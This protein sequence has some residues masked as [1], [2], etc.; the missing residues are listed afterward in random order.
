[1]EVLRLKPT[2]DIKSLGNLRYVNKE[3]ATLYG[4]DY[5]F[6]VL[7]NQLRFIPLIYTDTLEK[8]RHMAAG[9]IRAQ[10]SHPSAEIKQLFAEFYTGLAKGIFIRDWFV[11]RFDVGTA[12]RDWRKS[13]D[14]EKIKP[15]EGENHGSYFYSDP[16]N[17]PFVI[18]EPNFAKKKSR[19][20]I[21]NYKFAKD[22]RMV[23]IENVR[24]FDDVSNFIK[25]DSDYL[26]KF[27]ILQT[28]KSSTYTYHYRWVNNI[29]IHIFVEFYEEGD[30]WYCS[31]IDRI[32]QKISCIMVRPHMLST[33]NKVFLYG[34]RS[35][36]YYY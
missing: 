16:I 4:N 23:N 5:E 24:S 28:H 10:K 6:A 33:P 22:D 32:C 26:R 17:A 2:T 36:S 31:D 34:Y 8:C 1:M 21:P 30:R 29:E 35:W 9:L 13:F 7:R 20:T 14:V 19:R 3:C 12:W 25:I 18:T 15:W 27:K 11:T